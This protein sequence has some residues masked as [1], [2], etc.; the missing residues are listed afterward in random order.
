MIEAL[1]MRPKWAGARCYR[2]PAEFG[3]GRV[4]QRVMARQ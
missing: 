1:A 2:M 4:A 3:S